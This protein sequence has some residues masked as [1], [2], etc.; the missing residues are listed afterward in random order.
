[1]ASP[2]KPH[3]VAT[4]K[5]VPRDQAVFVS[6]MTRRTGAADSKTEGTW[7]RVLFSAPTAA[8]LVP[9]MVRAAHFLGAA[10]FALEPNDGRATPEYMT[11]GGE[12]RARFDVRHDDEPGKPF[13]IAVVINMLK[14]HAGLD[15]RE[16]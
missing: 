1:M 15:T 13:P 2:K 10:N 12:Y 5:F 3:D 11:G 14:I 7:F 16:G 8:A 6:A 4:R 9:M